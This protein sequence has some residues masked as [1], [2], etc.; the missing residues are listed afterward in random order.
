METSILKR[1]SKGEIKGWVK[2]EVLDDFPPTFFDD[3]I[4]SVQEMGGEVIKESTWRW[5]AL[6]RLPNG[7][8]FFLKRDKTKGWMEG[9]K[10]LFSPSKGQKEF[11]V[12]SQ[13]KKRGLNIPQPLGWMEK[14]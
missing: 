4:S 5:A 1:V 12:A 3:P 11:F 2:G 14:V 7:R 13:M 10:Y 8:G 6:L 9:L